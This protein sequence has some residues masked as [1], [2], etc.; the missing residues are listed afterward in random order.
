VPATG[1][2]W[3]RYFRDRTLT[4]N[5]YRPRYLYQG[6]DPAAS[7]DYSQL[8]WKSGLLTQANSSC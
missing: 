8:P 7:G 6:M 4:I 2:D 3:R 1:S 5:P